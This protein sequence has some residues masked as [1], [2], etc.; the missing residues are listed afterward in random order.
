LSFGF[1][2]IDVNG[3]EGPQCLL[4][5][6]VLTVD[7]LKPNKSTVSLETLC[8]EHIGKAPEFFHRILKE[9]NK[10]K[11]AFANITTVASESLLTSFNIA[12]ELANV[13]NFI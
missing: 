4:W 2:N 10:Q 3:E 7:T 11:Q 6:K 5:M 9:F 1:T 12:T 8:A 13:K